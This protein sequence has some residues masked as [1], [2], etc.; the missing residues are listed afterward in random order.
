MSLC[1]FKTLSISCG[2][3]GTPYPRK[4]PAAAR[5][6]LPI[7]THSVCSIFVCLD[8]DMDAGVWDFQH[9]HIC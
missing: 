6:A 9:V 2:K 1:F 3:F 7:P 5:A 4:A 8:N